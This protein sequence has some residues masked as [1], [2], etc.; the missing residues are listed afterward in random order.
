MTAAAQYRSRKE[1]LVHQWEAFHMANPR[2]WKHYD[3]RAW[4]KLEEG[5]SHYGSSAIIE[6]IRYEVRLETYDPLN[7]G[8]KLNDHV[9]PY[10]ARLWRK[11]N[12]DHRT[13]IRTRRL[14]SED[15]PPM[16]N[17]QIPLG[18]EPDFEEWLDGRLDE[19][20]ERMRGSDDFD[21]E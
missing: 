17:E 10:Y 19:L 14:T 1:Q 9:S 3:R 18:L 8:V 16:K 2:V 21:L 4:Q 12:P 5:R 6:W 15:D 20:V 11:L 13:F 7:L